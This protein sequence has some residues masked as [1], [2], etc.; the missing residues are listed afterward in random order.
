M[1]SSAGSSDGGQEAGRPL[2]SK[3]L[4]PALGVGATPPPARPAVIW[5]LARARQI[6]KDS[7]SCRS[8]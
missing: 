5:A 1:S 3:G 8:E 7:A 2:R 4:L 6:A